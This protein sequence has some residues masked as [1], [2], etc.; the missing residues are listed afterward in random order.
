MKT[1]PRLL[2]PTILSLLAPLL[3]TGAT[4]C[5]PAPKG[6]PIGFDVVAGDWQGP[7]VSMQIS[8]AGVIKY[9][10]TRGTRTE[11]TGLPIA[12][13]TSTGFDVSL[14]GFGTHFSIEALPHD[15][16]GVRKMTVD[17]IE[18]T[19]HAAEAA[20]PADNDSSHDKPSGL[21]PAATVVSPT[22]DVER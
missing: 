9:E 17:G 2:L 21:P 18:Y 14:F 11:I 16:D 19:D 5:T 12:A 1:A 3:S 20:T 10:N 4:A 8:E 13:L 7:G 22:L 6:T 15:V